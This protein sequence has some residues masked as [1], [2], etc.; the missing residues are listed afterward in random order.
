M[1]DSSIDL[2]ALNREILLNPKA[3]GSNELVALLE[4]E[5]PGLEFLC[6]MARA[7]Y[8]L[9]TNRQHCIYANEV[10]GSLWLTDDSE[11]RGTGLHGDDY[12]DVTETVHHSIS[13][14]FDGSEI[15]L[16]FQSSTEM[17]HYAG[18]W[19]VYLRKCSAQDVELNSSAEALDLIDQWFSHLNESVKE[20]RKRKSPYGYPTDSGEF[21]GTCSYKLT[22]INGLLVDGP[23]FS[24]TYHEQEWEGLNEDYPQRW[25]GEEENS[26]FC[27]LHYLSLEQVGQIGIAA[28]GMQ[29]PGP[30]QH[31]PEWV[32]T[33]QEWD[34]HLWIHSDR[35]QESYTK[36]RVIHAPSSVACIAVGCGSEWDP[37]EPD[38]QLDPED[39]TDWDEFP[40]TMGPLLKIEVS[41]DAE[42]VPA[43]LEALL[44][45][46]RHLN[47]MRHS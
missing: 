15:E 6:P 39:H 30:N 22:S 4:L 45:Y 24:D 43:K 2:L 33:T 20:S 11:A 31:Y 8:W 36:G 44:P 29:A 40:E 13:T 14:K 21:I 10:L 47:R 34:E 7:I 19:S 16:G 26:S 27:W 46:W 5:K 37:A 3:A 35:I 18:F 38:N 41:R 25:D 32:P 17:V 12:A 28:N 42:Q 9:E 1:A 23:T